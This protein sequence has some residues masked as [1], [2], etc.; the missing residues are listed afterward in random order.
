MTQT[1]SVLSQ[2]ELYAVLIGSYLPSVRTSKTVQESERKPAMVLRPR[3][4]VHL[5]LVAELNRYASTRLPCDGGVLRNSLP[6]PGIDESA[7]AL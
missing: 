2:A 4:L 3:A 5:L 6:D 1:S 7:P